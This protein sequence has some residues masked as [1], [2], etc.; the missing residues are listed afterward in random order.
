MTAAGTTADFSP[1]T[2]TPVVAGHYRHAADHPDVYAAVPCYCGCDS[3]A[4]H[5]NLSDCFVRPDGGGWDP[6]A[7]GC[8]VCQDEAVA[9][10]RLLD[11]GQSIPHIR[12]AI[13]DQFGPSNSPSTT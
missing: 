3:F 2:L 1:D 13:I 6:H 5:A 10:R 7:A 4:D 8:G 9:L 11:D 12:A